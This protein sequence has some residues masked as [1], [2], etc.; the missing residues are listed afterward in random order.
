MEFVGYFYKTWAYKKSGKT[1][2]EESEETPNVDWIRAPVFVGKITRVAPEEEPVRDD[3]P[4]R[5]IFLSFAVLTIL[6]IAL[7]R[8]SLSKSRGVGSRARR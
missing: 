2:A 3:V 1:S 4:V 6:W 5:A 7:R 8:L